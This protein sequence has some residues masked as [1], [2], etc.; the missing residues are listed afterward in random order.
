VAGL[1][2]AEGE[3]APAD[4]LLEGFLVGNPTHPEASHLLAESYGRQGR[5][6]DALAVANSLESSELNSSLG[7]YLKGRLLYAQEDYAG[8][9]AA[10]TQVLELEPSA[11]EALEYLTRSYLALDRQEEAF[12]YLLKH[13]EN[14]P[15]QPHARELLGTMYMNTGQADEAIAS[16]QAGLAIA[17][18]RVSTLLGL[19]RAFQASGDLQTTL[20]TY[21]KALE[22]APDNVTF[23]TLKADT[24]TA[25]EQF[26]QAA[27]VYEAVLVIDSRQKVAANNL[28]MLLLDRLPTEQGL[29]RAL[30]IT[31]GFEK[32]RIPT[33]WDT[34][35]WVLYHLEDYESALP[36]QK[37]AVESDN[38]TNS[39]RYHLGMTYLKLNDTE[40][41]HAEFEASLEDGVD[42][43]GSDV[44]REIV[45]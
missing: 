23:M 15:D 7:S 3:L 45:R 37:R 21:D 39:F 44:A 22:L 29:Q 13:I 30:E 38:V 16:Y 17:P 36:L 14:Y 6:D 20:D 26:P 31:A 8:S 24:L 25:M 27:E 40:S 10:F 28:A 35:G 9:L 33:F 12:A 41:A 5:W 32:T 11:I 2:I 34:R 1:L 19:A 42:Y 4:R 18:E 43:Y